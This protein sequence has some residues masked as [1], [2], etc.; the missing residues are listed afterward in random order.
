VTPLAELLDQAE[1]APPGERIDLRDRIAAYGPEALP[2]LTRW[3]VTD[4]LG[5]FSARVIEE[6]A[7]KHR[8]PAIRA[9]RDG[10]QH[11]PAGVLREIDDALARIDPRGGGQPT[12]R[13]PRTA[14]ADTEQWPGNRTASPL[15]LRFHE[16]MLNIFR[17]AGEATRRVRPDGTIAR[18]Y[19]ASYFLRGVRSHGGPEYARYLLRKRGVSDGFRRLSDEGRLD[20]SVEA[21]VLKPEYA[22]LFTDAEKRTATDRLGEGHH[23]SIEGNASG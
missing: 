6:I 15:E 5:F 2:P 18:G 23:I 12:I 13:T 7:K 16:A 9:L 19:W 22:E 14:R 1:Q 20:L 21:L 8:Q 17:L 3:L 11:A 4:R 10:R